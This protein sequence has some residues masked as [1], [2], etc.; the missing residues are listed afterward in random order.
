MVINQVRLIGWLSLIRVNSGCSVRRWDLG[1]A[2]NSS[3]WRVRL[4]NSPPQSWFWSKTC[5]IPLMYA[6]KTGN[7]LKIPKTTKTKSQSHF[8]GP[9]LKFHQGACNRN[10]QRIQ[11]WKMERANI[12]YCACNTNGHWIWS[13]EIWVHVNK[14]LHGNQ[15]Q[16]T[17]SQ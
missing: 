17:I 13:W 11:T 1:A 4:I 16:R 10:G 7:N 12:N 9:I 8:E 15:Y 14:M 6:W 5:T 3:S 2:Q